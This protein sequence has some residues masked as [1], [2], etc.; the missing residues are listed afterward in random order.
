MVK[1]QVGL[2]GHIIK[3]YANVKYFYRFC[4]WVTLK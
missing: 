2:L 1:T 4:T 3:K